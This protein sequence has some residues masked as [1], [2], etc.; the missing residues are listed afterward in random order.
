[1]R[2][3]ARAAV[4]AAKSEL[5]I[6]SPS[7]VFRDEVG[8]MSMRGW[9]QGLMLE[10]KSQARTITNAARYLTEAAKESAVAYNSQDNRRT[11]HQSSSVNLT[12]NSFYVRD[13][14]DIRALAIEIAALT[15][16]Q[17]QG[18]GQR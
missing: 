11:Y 7:Q 6:Q 16:R 12:G 15:K 2:A 10:S 17:H 8:R 13:D 9:G 1:M 3:A 18:R 14:K 5:K 4:N